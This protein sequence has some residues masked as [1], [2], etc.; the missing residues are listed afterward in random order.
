MARTIVNTGEPIA[1]YIGRCSDRTCRRVYRWDV[2]EEVRISNPHIMP[3]TLTHAHL[4]LVAVMPRCTAHVD[5]L[6][7]PSRTWIRFRPLAATYVEG[8]RCTRT[9]HNATSITCECACGG[10][11]HGRGHAAPE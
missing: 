7:R 8:V 2:P 4:P 1:A 5:G 10:K 6:G 3:S 9:C 11:N